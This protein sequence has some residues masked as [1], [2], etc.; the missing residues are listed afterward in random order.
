[1]GFP[2]GA[3]GAGAAGAIGGGLIGLLGGSPY[4]DAESGY[5]NL[6]DLLRSIYGP[7][8]SAATGMIPGYTSSLS[9]LTG[10]PTG[11]EDSIMSK[12]STSP[13]AQYQTQQATQAGDRAAAAGGVL[14]TP[15]MQQQMAGNIQGIVS[16]DQG[17]YLQNAIQP[18]EFGLGQQGNFINMGANM[19]NNFGNQ[20]SGYYGNMAGMDYGQAANRQQDYGQLLSGLIQ[21]GAAAFGGPAGAGA[22]G[23][24]INGPGSRG[25]PTPFS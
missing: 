22:M 14:G 12:Y 5:Q 6:S 8:M 11:L 10:N 21:G 23:P 2:G 18:Y 4:G 13:M 19:A 17:Q 9:G 3:G 24:G 7:Y 16:Q 15:A 20:M 25:L 1:M